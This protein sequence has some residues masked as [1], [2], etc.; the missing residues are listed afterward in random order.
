MRKMSEHESPIWYEDQVSFMPDMD[1][2][3]QQQQQQQYSHSNLNNTYHYHPNYNNCKK[4]M[5][6]HYQIPQ[7]HHFLQQLPLLESPKLLQSAPSS[8][9]PN[10]MPAA[11]GLNM[12]HGSSL[13][14]SLLQVQQE[15]ILHQSQDHHHPLHNSV[16]SSDMSND[17]GGDQVATDWRVLDKF[18]ASQLSQEELSKENDYTNANNNFRGSDDSNMM[19]K[20]S[21]K[22]EMATENVS[23]SSSS[24]QIDMWK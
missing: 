8:V 3:K 15:H 20:D 16:Y 4:E 11:F 21:E 12:N 2:P 18:V 13:Q 14:P 7:D 24:C 5:D 23:T 6:F 22:Q 10:S 17:Q 9:V 1:S 19:I